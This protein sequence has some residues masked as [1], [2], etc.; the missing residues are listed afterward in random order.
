MDEASYFRTLAREIHDN[1]KSK[2]EGPRKEIAWPK[3]SVQICDEDTTSSSL[4]NN[5]TQ[6]E[7]VT[8]KSQCERG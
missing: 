8:P 6:Y 2:P 7:N 1:A 4:K 5:V 3:N